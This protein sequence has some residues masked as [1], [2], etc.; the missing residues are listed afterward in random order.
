MGSKLLKEIINRIKGKVQKKAVEEPQYIYSV[1]EGIC[2]T[3][4]YHIA[5]NGKCLC[6]NKDT[7]PTSI[8]LDSWGVRTHLKE[9]YCKKCEEIL[10]G[11]HE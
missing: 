7:M 4:F 5:L 6:G 9:R 3:F 10:R 8:P 1:R 2:G 11:D